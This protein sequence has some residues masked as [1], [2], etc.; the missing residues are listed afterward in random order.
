LK[1]VKILNTDYKKVI[2]DYNT[3]NSFF[4]LDPP[5][6]GSSSTHYENFNIDYN[7]L[8]NLVKSIKGK[9]LMSL[10][11][12]NENREL[13]KEYNIYNVKTKYANPILGGMKKD[14]KNELLI[15]NYN[16]RQS[17]ISYWRCYIGR[18]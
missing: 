14:K 1:N 17:I 18:T 12:S 16:T 6:R 10:D 7:E 8:Y 9:F 5:Y 3:E 15:S 4:Y 13:F 2:K 11:D